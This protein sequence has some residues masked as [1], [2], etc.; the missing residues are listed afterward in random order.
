MSDILD[1]FPNLSALHRA[2]ALAHGLGFSDVAEAAPTQ[3][4]IARQIAL[5]DYVRMQAAFDDLAG[6]AEAP[7]PFMS[8]ALVAAAAASTGEGRIVVLAAFDIAD[9]QRLIGA[10]CLRRER[11]LWSLGREV[12]QVPILP[13][14][15]CLAAPVLDKAHAAAALAAILAHLKASPDLPDIIRATSWPTALDALMPAGWRASPA[16]TWQRAILHA[17]PVEGA[18][19]YLRHAMGKSLNKR[20]SRQKQLGEL[21]EVAIRSI[22]GTEA[23]EA[24]EHYIRLEAK[25]WK[26]QCGTS[27]SE[28]PA[29]AAYMRAAIGK[30]AEADKIAVDMITLDGTPIAVGV[31]VEAAGSNLFWKAAFDE[32]HSRFAPGSLLHLAVTRRLFAEGRARLDSGMMEFT[33]PAYLPWSERAGMARVIIA[34]GTGLAGR[35]V[36]AGTNVRH[37]VRRLKRR[38]AE[39]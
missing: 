8:P 25:G 31:V 9:P 26:G 15:E 23:S 1:R 29:D 11:D 4:M 37:A 30:L 21:G 27:L 19:T 28:A 39:R 3:S 38:L 2:K 17:D 13:R 16:E 14:Y 12:L 36:R 33:S 18:E 22:R 34:S 32:E 6:R 10:W 7:N 24:F 5:A 35:M 20:N